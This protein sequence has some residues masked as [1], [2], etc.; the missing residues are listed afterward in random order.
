[1]MLRRFSSAVAL[2]SIGLIGCHN[3]FAGGDIV[4]PA[5]I[6]PAIVVEI[7]DA[8]TGVP[9]ADNA[10]GAVHDVAYTDSLTPYEGRATSAGLELVSR[11]AADER[12][13]TYFVEVTHPGYRTWSLSGVRVVKGQCGVKTRRLS[14]AL[15]ASP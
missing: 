11:R 3:P 1:M 4:C 5:V 6:E 9:L 7:R 2:G 15:Q 10:R 14:A 8:Q 12:P 13:G